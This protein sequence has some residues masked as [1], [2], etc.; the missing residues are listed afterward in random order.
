[1]T[2]TPSDTSARRSPVG[3]NLAWK[4]LLMLAGKLGF[5]A[6]R[7]FTGAAGTRSPPL[8]FTRDGEEAMQQNS[9]W[10]TGRHV[11]RLL[12]ELHAVE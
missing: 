4:A 6:K 9:Q 8:S 10:T 12:S 1:M 7:I 11:Q 3:E 2:R 5:G